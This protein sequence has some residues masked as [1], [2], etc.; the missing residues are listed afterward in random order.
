MLNFRCYAYLESRKFRIILIGIRKESRIELIQ[1]ENPKQVYIGMQICGT[2]ISLIIIDHN[3]NKL[4]FQWW[5]PPKYFWMMFCNMK[6][7][8]DDNQ[9]WPRAEG[10]GG[11][12]STSFC[13]WLFSVLHLFVFFLIIIVVIFHHPNVSKHIY[14]LVFHFQFLFILIILNNI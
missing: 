5:L 7:H 6:F 12:Q 4:P 14:F 11:Y 2:T 13:S 8:D 10:C 9:L 1:Q 3:Q